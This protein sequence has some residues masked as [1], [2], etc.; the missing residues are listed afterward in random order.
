MAKAHV[1]EIIKYFTTIHMHKLLLHALMNQITLLVNHKN[2]CSCCSY[3]QLKHE[4]GNININKN[5][6]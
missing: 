2:I 4:S 1:L 3:L 5:L 6:F